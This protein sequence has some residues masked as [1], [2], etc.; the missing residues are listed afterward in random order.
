M[1]DPTKPPRVD[2]RKLAL[3][4]RAFEAEIAGALTTRPPVMQTRSKLAEELVGDGL[5]VKAEATLPGRFPLRVA[6]YMLTEAGRLAYCQ[7]AATAEGI[8]DG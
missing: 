3:L 8:A 2:A 7:H 1:T 6:G 4:E 5:L